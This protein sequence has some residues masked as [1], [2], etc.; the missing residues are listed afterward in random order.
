MIQFKEEM[1]LSETEYEDY[2]VNVATLTIE[3]QRELGL[4]KSC[5][6]STGGCSKKSGAGSCCGS[7][8]AC[9]KS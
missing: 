7:K 5:C 2:D 1:L 4:I 9:P 6:G 3:D 8:K